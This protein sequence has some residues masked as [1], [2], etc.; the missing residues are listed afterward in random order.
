MAKIPID[1]SGK[2]GLATSYFGDSDQTNPSPNRQY[3]AAPGEMMDGFFNP[4]RRRGFLSASVATLGAMTADHAVNA[5]LGSCIYDQINT[6]VYYAERSAQIF[7]QSGLDSTALVRD[8]ALSSNSIHDL[9]IYQINGVRKL[10]YV[11]TQPIASSISTTLGSSVLWSIFGNSVFP[12]GTSA[13]S[14]TTSVRATQA[15]GATLTQSFTVPAGTNGLLFVYAVNYTGTAAS[16]A[17]FNGVSMTLKNTLVNGSVSFT[18][19]YI[20]APAA[21]TANVVVTWP[22]SQ[23]NEVV[24][25]FYIQGANQTTPLSGLFAST[26]TSTT[27][28]E[29]IIYNTLNTLMIALTVS[30]TATHTVTAG[31]QIFNSTNTVGNDSTTYQTVTTENLMTGIADLPFANKDDSWLTS[32]VAGATTFTTTSSYNFMRVADNGFAYLFADNQIHKIDGTLTTGGTD[33]TFSPQVVVF[34]TYFRLIDAVDWRG[35]I[36]AV[37]HQTSVDTST[38]N[39]TG[40]NYVNTA[41]IYIWDRQST[42]VNMSDYIPVFGVIAIKKIFVG[43]N[44]NIR[45]YCIGANGL[46]QIREFTGS[47]FTVIEELG[48]GSMPQ[49]VDSECEI[50]LG[51]VWLGNDGTIYQY[52]FTQVGQGEKEQ[53]AKI[54]C[55]KAPSTSTPGTNLTE[56]GVVFYGGSNTFSA[57]AGYRT[58]RQGLTVCYNDAASYLYKKVYPW[59]EGTINSNNQLSLAGNVY[60]PIFFFQDLV[61]VNYF[62]LYHN[63]GSVSGSTQQGTLSIYLNQSTTPFESIAI[64]RNDI[65]KGWKYVLVGQAQNKNAVFA[66]Q[67]KIAWATDQIMSDTYDWLPRTISVDYDSLTKL[68]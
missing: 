19:F 25:I 61:K 13:P 1:I 18:S 23:N 11:Y 29:S 45:M 31:T 53:I 68:Q 16:S 7:H 48:L 67:F 22:T 42:V 56:T 50:E 65:V 30:A 9:E 40:N 32:T 36:Y 14:I 62:H 52:A 43:T 2:N 34:P 26:N 35:N 20:V 39:S 8:T 47:E 17:T 44:G 54:G 33:G 64:T 24:N 38:A 51:R 28:D 10:F 27:A 57:A 12:S 66:I 5:V 21:A 58:D 59:D 55:V 49:Y 63:V 3:V 37:I 60:S 15:S 41:G 6:T 46:G 4:F